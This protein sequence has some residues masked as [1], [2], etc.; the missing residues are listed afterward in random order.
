MASPMTSSPSAAA[1]GRPA[2]ASARR[3]D[4]R[5]RLDDVLKLMVGEGLVAA[6]EAEKLARSRSSRVEH[7]LE[8]IGE[9]KWKSLAPPH[10]LITLEGLVEWLAGKLGVPYLHIDP[11]KIDLTA[12]TQTMSNAYAERFRILPV[13]V[14]RDVLTVATSEPFV[15]SGPTSSPRCCTS[16]SSWCSP[17]RS[18]SGATSGSS[19]TS[20][21]R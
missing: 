4:Q 7:P 5:L 8:M 1:P 16:R 21:A 9:Q 15:R 11:L 10:R 17:I 14:T 12:V 19:T 13:A 20:R 6:A 18:T 3:P 2:G